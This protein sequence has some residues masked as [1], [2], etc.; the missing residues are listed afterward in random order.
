MIDYNE[1]FGRRAPAVSLNI[2]EIRELVD[3]SLEGSRIK[4]ISLL[5]GGF[6]NSN[7]RLHLADNTSLVLRISKL[8]REFRKELRVLDLVRGQATTPEVIAKSFSKQFPFALIEFVEG[9]LLSMVMS[10]LNDQ[11]LEAVA[12]EAGKALRRVHSFDLGKAGFFDDQF[13]FNLEFENFGRAWYDYICSTLL[14]D[15]VR[16]RLGITVAEQVLD[17][18]RDRRATYESI[19][20]T[21]RLIHC[22]YNPK[23]IIISPIDSHWKVAAILDWE[24]AAS[25]SPLVD[26]GNFL[27]FDDELPAGFDQGFIQGYASDPGTFEDNWREITQLLDLAAMTNFLDSESENPK[28]FRTAVSVIEKT[29]KTLGKK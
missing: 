27:R 17:F 13:V 23:N 7:Y 16:Q 12:I 10:S 2:D 20:N 28:T 9:E 8:V 4:S 24:F 5:G 22:D 29:I 19:A 21:T 25:G 6:V 26:L 1:K 15:R 18:V 14:S 3:P 11:V